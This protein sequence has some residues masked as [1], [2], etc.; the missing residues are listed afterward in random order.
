MSDRL[1]SFTLRMC[2]PLAAI[3]LLALPGTSLGAKLT[4]Q[5]EKLLREAKKEGSVTVINPLFQDSTTKAFGDAFVKFYGLGPNFK[6][7]NLRKG[8]GAVVAQVRQEIQAGKFTADA[9]FVNN[10]PFF[11][12]AAKQGAFLALDSGRWKDFAAGVKKA[13][14]YS[15]YPYVVT[16][17]AY[18]FVPVWNANCPGMAN[19]K[20]D[21]FF[22]A[23]SPALKGKTIS[24]DITK[25]STYTNTVIGLMEAGVDVNAFWDKLKAT[26]PIVEFRTEPKIQMVV[27][28]ERPFDMFNLAIR[29]FQGTEGKPELRK[30]IR[31]GSYKEGHVMLGNQ[32]AVLKGA[33]KPNAAKLMVEFFLTKEGA[34]LMARYENNY[35]FLAGWKIPEDIRSWMHELKPLGLKDWVGAGK[36][37]KPVRDEWIKRFK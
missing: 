25:S 1:R 15:N 34:D 33:A 11:A 24:P 12:A 36:K 10:P 35:S 30:H 23:A 37:F 5:E 19:V 13:G 3:A 14:Q 6:F 17:F 21:S 22:D 26:D 18:T 31:I 20:I 4:P 2:A 32:M 27:K 7:N 9:V 8:T 28:C 29:V 16:P